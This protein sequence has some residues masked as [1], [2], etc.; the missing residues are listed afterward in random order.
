[1]KDILAWFSSFFIMIAVYISRAI[2]DYYAGAPDWVWQILLLNVAFFILYGILFRIQM[3]SEDE[4]VSLDGLLFV[5]HTIVILTFFVIA[6]SMDVFIPQL[7]YLAEGWY[8]VIVAGIGLKCVYRM[9]HGIAE[10]TGIDVDKDF[11]VYICIIRKIKENLFK[12][13]KGAIDEAQEE[14]E[15]PEEPAPDVIDSAVLFEDN[16]TKEPDKAN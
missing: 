12:V 14:T 13:I 4:G 9:L 15:T 3:G 2:S 5:R 8:A 10:G 11:A 1:M 16:V 6:L 7:K